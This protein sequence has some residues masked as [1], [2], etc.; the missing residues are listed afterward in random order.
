[1]KKRYIVY[2]LLIVLLLQ[3]FIPFIAPVRP[4]I[5]LPGEVI[6]PWPNGYDSFGGL[7]GR[8]F[9][10]TFLATCLT[11]VIVVLIALRLGAKSKGV[12]EVPS[13]FYNFFEM[14]IEGAYGYVENAAGKWAKN[15]FPFFMTFI[16]WIVVAN[17]M[18][19]VP[20][21]DSIGKWETMGE[22]RKHQLEATAFAAGEHPEEKDLKAVEKAALELDEGDLRVWPFLISRAAIDE[23]AQPGPEVHDAPTGRAAEAADWTLVPY[24]RAAATDLN[25]TLAVAIISVIMTQYYGM[26]AQGLKYW[27]KFFTWNGDKIKENPLAVM[28]TGVG[29]LEFI[30][31]V[32]KIVSFAFRLLGN[33]FAGQVLLFVIGSLLPI[34]NLLFWFLEFG[35]GLLQGVVFALLTL[36]FMSGA[37]ESHDHH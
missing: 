22:L 25:F 5:Q 23:G 21:V 7:F 34:G 37:T 28:D 36:T 10:N 4:F 8:G 11:F 17:W 30:S 26:R 1:M 33:I 13:G 14:L 6:W 32:F 20:G 19:L 3:S 15:F 9:T 35:I 24:V 27:G 16:L 2:I 12:D 18:E 29:I 31:E